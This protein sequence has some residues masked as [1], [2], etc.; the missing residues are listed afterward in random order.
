MKAANDIVELLKMIKDISY[1]YKT[2]S[3][4]FN[5]INNAMRSFYLLY[6]KDAFT[7]EQYMESFLNNIGIIKHS[8]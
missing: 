3:Y 2:Q 7:L 1:K 4:P 5:V 8:N 6:Q